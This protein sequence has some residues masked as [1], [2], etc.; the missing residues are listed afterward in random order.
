MFAAGC[1]MAALFYV[2]V[3]E[4]CFLIAPAIALFTPWVRTGAPDP[5]LAY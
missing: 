4:W 1:G 5:D 2:A 3:R